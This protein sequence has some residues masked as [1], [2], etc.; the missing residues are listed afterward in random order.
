MALYSPNENVLGPGSL[1]ECSGLEFVA[2]SLSADAF[3]VL[4]SAKMALK[5]TERQH[6]NPSENNSK[7]Y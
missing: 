1:P 4:G 3:L 2:Y 5:A 6:T 7:L